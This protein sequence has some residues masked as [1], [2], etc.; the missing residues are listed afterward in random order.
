[1]SNTTTVKQGYDLSVGDV[2]VDA[3]RNRYVIVSGVLQDADGDWLERRDLNFVDGRWVASGR[4]YL[5]EA[6]DDFE[7]VL[8]EVASCDAP[9]EFP[10]TADEVAANQATHD[11]D[12]EFGR[13]FDCDCR[14]WGT[15]SQW[16]C[17][18]DVPRTNDPQAVAAAVA[19]VAGG[20]RA[21]S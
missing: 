7:V 15:V 9:L 21:W 3:L 18:A 10:G 6:D 17:G 2:T 14:P 13:C 5:V 12:Y 1:M 16:P 8:N 20:G 19:R 11:F 4:I